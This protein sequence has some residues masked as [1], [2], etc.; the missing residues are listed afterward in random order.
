MHYLNTKVK[1]FIQR[2][3]LRTTVS[4][5]VGS[6]V[7]RT[8]QGQWCFTRFRV[9]VVES[10]GFVASHLWSI[11]AIRSWMRWIALSGRSITLKST[12]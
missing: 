3:V 8:S 11:A 12:I 9:E 10:G 4:Q 2:D 7:S 1:V 5:G 6:E